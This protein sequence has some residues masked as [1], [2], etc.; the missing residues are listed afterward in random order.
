M[1]PR[2]SA[3]G[4]E[5][6]H[7]PVGLQPTSTH[8]HSGSHDAASS[9]TAS[10]PVPFPE[11]INCEGSEL[12]HRCNPHSELSVLVPDRNQARTTSAAMAMTHNPYG[13]PT[14]LGQVCHDA[15]TTSL[16]LNL[17]HPPPC[18]IQQLYY[19]GAPPP[20]WTPAPPSPYLYVDDLCVLVTGPKLYKKNSTS[21]GGYGGN[22][23]GVGSYF[24]H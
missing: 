4:R 3:T 13:A 24:E 15:H 20:L 17:V 21:V 12:R 23:G 19:T 2:C 10:G 9:S 7:D 22:Q 14:S 6:K 11:R 8:C 1:Q 5:D 16:P 18:P